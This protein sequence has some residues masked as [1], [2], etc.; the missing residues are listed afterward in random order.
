MKKAFEGMLDK[1][2][3]CACTAEDLCAGAAYFALT[4][5]DI[6]RAAAA[7]PENHDLKYKGV[8]LLLSACLEEFAALF[9]DGGRE[10]C[11]VSVPAPPFV[12]YALQSAGDGWRFVSGAFFT[13]I[14]LRGILLNREAVDITSCAKR[15]CGLN[16]MRSRI[17]RQPMGKKILRQLQFGLLC[18]ECVKT[19]EALADRI[20]NISVCFP[21][22][23]GERVLA[24]QTADFLE[25]VCG[26]F[27]L[28]LER[29]HTAYAFQLYAR[30]MSAENKI[31]RLNGR[32]DRMPL[33]GNS[34]ALAQSVQLMT[35]DRIESFVSALELLADELENAPASREERRLYC[36]FTPFLQPEIDTGFRGNGV[37]LLGNAAFLQRGRYVGT[38]LPGMTA[39]WLR[40]MNIRSGTEEECA[41]IAKA[42]RES[43]CEAYLTGAFGFDRWLGAGV[44]MQRRILSERYGIAVKTLDSDFWCENAMFGNVQSRID[45][46]CMR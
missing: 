13:Q 38:D 22:G 26:R 1:L 25:Q 32:K 23:A 2:P 17:L 7:L 36:Y 3:E 40:G 35:T 43:G 34:L 27:S 4:E 10:L 37:A 5:E 12:M 42:V 24:A 18:D 44:Q 21:K 41:A 8:R 20:E 28:S 9:S 33:Y 11:E 15:H 45:M 29:P 14:V 19:G 6:R 46:M 16:K 30:L 39:A 31:Q